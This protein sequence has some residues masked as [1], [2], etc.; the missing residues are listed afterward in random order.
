MKPAILFDFDGTLVTYR[1]NFPELVLSIPRA[2]ELPEDDH[3]RFGDELVQ[4]L[5]LDKPLTLRSSI[6]DALHALGYRVPAQLDEVVERVLEDYGRDVELLPGALTLLEKASEAM[7]LA[8]VTNGPSDMQRR[9][10]AMVGIEGYFKAVV[11]S[12]DEDVGVRKPSP[13]IFR[14]A[15]ER[16]GVPPE[17][18]MVIGDNLQADIHGALAAGMQAIE[19]GPEADLAELFEVIVGHLESLS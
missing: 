3:E 7:P 11:I 13:L 1:G 17:R 4:Q 14:L 15:C 19:V 5:F 6:V 18:A 8:L 12:G 2:L 16:L 10:I 9:A